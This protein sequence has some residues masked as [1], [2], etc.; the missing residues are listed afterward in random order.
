MSTIKIPPH[1]YHTATNLPCSHCQ[2]EEA[3]A[4]EDLLPAVLDD[5]HPG[6]ALHDD[7][8]GQAWRAAKRERQIR[9]LLQ[10]HNQQIVL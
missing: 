5:D 9:G 7:E 10:G 8:E 2:A 3:I 4:F 1:Y 6:G